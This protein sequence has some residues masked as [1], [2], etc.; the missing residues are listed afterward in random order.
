[1]FGKG[2]F[3]VD[4]NATPEQIKQKR[5]YI[6][7]MMPKFGK[8]SYVGEGIGQLATGVMIGRQNRKLD[9]AESAGR[10]SAVEMLK[11]I[12]GMPGFGSGST[13]PGSFGV[14]GAAPMDGASSASAAA[15]SGTAALGDDAMAALGQQPIRDYRES[16][17]GTES[18]GRWDAANNET[19]AGGKAGHFGRVQF[20]HA[21]LQEAMD[22]GVIPQGTTPEQ[23][24]A[25]PELQMAAEDW[26]FQDLETKLA[27][28]VGTVVNGQ[29][30]DIGALVAMGHLGGAG[31]AAKFVQSGGAYN[32]SDSFGTSLSD[33]AQKHGGTVSPFAGAGAP[34]PAG[35]NAATPMVPT[36]QLLAAL[37]NPWLSEQE[38]SVLASI[39][40]QQVQAGDPMRQL[41]LQKAQMEVEAMRNP[42]AKPPEELTTRMLL[43]E[44]AGLDPQSPEGQNYLLTGE[45]PE[46]PE[47]GYRLLSAAEA[48]QMGLPPGASYQVGPKGE[49][50]TVGG[51]GQT[52]NVNTGGT[53]PDLGKLSTD[54]GYVLDP[55]TGKAKIDPA[56]GLPVA[57]PVPGSPAAIEAQKVAQAGV[58]AGGADT[59]ATETITTAASRARDAAAN[60]ELGGFGAG[61]AAMNP[62][63]DSAEVERQID[64]LRANAA[65]TTLQA[66]RDAS[67]TGSTGLGALT[68]PEMKV[69]QDKAGALNQNSPNFLRDLEDYER[70]LL[71]T[72][73]GPEAGDRIY[74]ATRPSTAPQATDAD[75]W[76]TL[77]SGVKVRVKQ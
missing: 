39:Y 10:Q 67:P 47:A 64:V 40:D 6:A 31:G 65:T 75:G 25:S 60:R 66:M 57:A 74:E 49:I 15:P 22:A 32:P 55:E 72:I 3:T 18:G 45:L 9:S 50:K 68:A 11:G 4:A 30:M 29:E 28:Y 43:M 48:T 73:H 51:A 2:A 27:P 71:R 37:S 54:F 38:R 70:T 19:G 8:A 7:A 46:A 16:L 23:F 69:I 20:G 17:I 59:V 53:G 62:Y 33:Y 56:T 63:S 36:D 24:K 26:H 14:L 5:A 34:A 76:Q 52:I 35:Y 61:L 77:P 42:S 1:M 12:P 58:N 44:Q 21:R 13:A 41:E